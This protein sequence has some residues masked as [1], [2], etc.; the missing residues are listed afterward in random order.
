MRDS[1]SIL[2]VDDNEEARVTV[3]RILEMS[4]YGV[5]QAANAKSASAL[6]KDHTPD[7]VITDIFMPEGDGFEMLSELRD[8][9]PKIPV[10]AMS[11]G[12]A[13]NGLDVLAIAGRLGAKK[14]LYKP[15]ARRQLLDAITEALA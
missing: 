2:L 7:L 1:A 8:R 4:G 15:F 12:G 11:G 10:I 14:V 3:A 9:D 6:L 5:V 13:H